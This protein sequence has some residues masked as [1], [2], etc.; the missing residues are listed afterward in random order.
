MENKDAADYVKAVEMCGALGP[1]EYRGRQRKF[2]FL[3]HKRYK[4]KGLAGSNG[5]R[6]R[7]FSYESIS[8]LATMKTAD[9][10]K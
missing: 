7:I 8:R 4:R 3:P 5:G 9:H 1:R 2:R 10:K 6:S